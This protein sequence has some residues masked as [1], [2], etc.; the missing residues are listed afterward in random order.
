MI[1]TTTMFQLDKKNYHSIEANQR[2]MSV[3]QFKD[4]VMCE[5]SALAKVKGNYV[6]PSSNALLV[7]S[8]THAAFES[9]EVV[10]QFIEENNG[11]IFN[12]RGNKYSDFLKADEMI[13][14]IKND[15]FC[16][17]AMTGDKEVI[18]TANLWGTEWKIKVD[19]INHQQRFFS[20]L[21]TTQ[22]LHKRYWSDKYNN[23][24]SFVEA[25]DYVLQMA[26]YRRVI[27]ENLGYTYTPYI[28]G[29]SK[30]T[31]P[32]KAVLHF[33]ESRFDFEYEYLEMKMERILDVKSEKVEPVRCEKCE[34]CRGSKKLSNT[35]EIGEL[36][37]V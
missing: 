1:M 36:I 28:V 6:P 5:A 13:E 29:V 4:F 2:Y 34:Y 12:N 35:M 19:N 15:P 16:M 33:D 24:V 11:A 23:W 37:H 18:Y 14:T 17:F 26:V 9:E 25:W 10:N 27:Q 7:G 3:S 20:D 21:K 30:E 32:N 8:Y 31:K 22:D